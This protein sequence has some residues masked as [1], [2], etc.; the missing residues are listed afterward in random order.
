[1]PLEGEGGGHEEDAVS[2]VR[3]MQAAMLRTQARIF[4]K[5]EQE[6]QKEEDEE[7]GQAGKSGHMKRATSGQRKDRREAARWDLAHWRQLAEAI[8]EKKWW[9]RGRAGATAVMREP[10]L[11]RVMRQ[12]GVSRAERRRTLEDLCQKRLAKAERVY[13]TAMGARDGSEMVENMMVAT[14]EGAGGGVTKKVFEVVR[15][16]LAGAAGATGNAKL[17]EVFVNTNGKPETTRQPLYTAAEVRE[18]ARKYGAETMATGKAHKSAA[19]RMM[20]R[21]WTGLAGKREEGVDQRDGCAASGPG[22]EGSFCHLAQGEENRRREKI[23]FTSRSLSRRRMD[24]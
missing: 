1:M 2:K 17:T 21:V 8:T 22:N 23:L 18:E 6:G 7:Q 4:G 24:M 20:A 14:K 16:C 5:Q 13:E 11:R 10:V 3:R 12:Q 9:R 15:A 19:R